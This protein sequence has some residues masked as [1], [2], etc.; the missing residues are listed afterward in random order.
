M[1]DDTTQ[2]AEA[3]RLICEVRDPAGTVR[4]K[5]GVADEWVSF[6]AEQG[7]MGYETVTVKLPVTHPVFREAY[8]LSGVSKTFYE[9]PARWT[10][11]VIYRGYDWRDGSPT[12]ASLNDCLAKA[13]VIHVEDADIGDGGSNLG[14]ITQLAT[15]TSVSLCDRTIGQRQTMHAGWARYRKDGGPISASYFVKHLADDQTDNSKRPPGYLSAGGDATDYGSLSR[16][17]LVVIES[18]VSSTLSF[19]RIDSGNSVLDTMRE[20]SKQFDIGWS[21]RVSPTGNTWRLHLYDGQGAN[22]TA[23]VIFNRSNGTLIGVKRVLDYSGESNTSWVSGKGTRERQLSRIGWSVDATSKALFGTLETGERHDSAWENEIAIESGLL[24]GYIANTYERWEAEVRDTDDQY[25]GQHY[26]V[27]DTVLVTD[28][29]RG[30]SLT[31]AILVVKVSSDSPSR[32]RLTLG[33][34]PSRVNDAGGGGRSS[35]GGVGHRRAGGATAPLVT[36]QEVFQH[37][38]PDDGELVHA[39]QANSPLQVIGDTSALRAPC[40]PFSTFGVNNG[41]GED[42]VGQLLGIV[43]E[44]EV[45]PP[46]P[47]ADEAVNCAGTVDVTV[48]GQDARTVTKKLE[49]F[50]DGSECNPCAEINDGPEE[51][52]FICYTPGTVI[53]KLVCEEGCTNQPTYRLPQQTLDVVC[54]GEVNGCTVTIP[55]Q[56]L[57]PTAGQTIC[58]PCSADVVIPPANE[59][60]DFCMPYVSIGGQY[61]APHSM[62]IRETEET[63]CDGIDWAADLA[64]DPAVLTDLPVTVTCD[65]VP[66]QYPWD[67]WTARCADDGVNRESII[68]PGIRTVVECTVEEPMPCPAPEI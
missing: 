33:D 1:A 21:F 19:L 15:I 17:G 42:K 2:A 54:N 3:S 13:S 36:E 28:E 68:S 40:N 49:A 62:C 23:T 32:V 48:P 44:H 7:R 55:A 45:V 53:G 66:G 5:F 51:Q 27:G 9:R 34:L 11:W 67:V 31:K 64:R 12:G 38:C 52:R 58:D 20:L 18:S 29:A 41:E 65:P 30:V 25:F 39:T 24:D 22:R 8:T 16:G 57:D 46:A 63:C 50:C 47:P 60:D 59:G 37:I 26:A 10:L 56:D 14:D 35:R 6:S 61:I 4:A 43:C